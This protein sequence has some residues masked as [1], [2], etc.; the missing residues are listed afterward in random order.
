MSN[1]PT[2]RPGSCGGPG[3]VLIDRLD[4]DLLGDLVEQVLGHAL[5]G[6]VDQHVEGR[7]VHVGG[8]GDLAGG[9][10]VRELVRRGGAGE[11][12]RAEGEQRRPDPGVNCHVAL[13]V[14]PG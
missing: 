2:S 8:G 3:E 1:L 11:T 9:L 13:L 10:D 4:A 6:A 14:E 5:V 7:V 12:E